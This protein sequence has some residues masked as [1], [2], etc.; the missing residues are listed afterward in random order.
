MTIFNRCVNDASR[1]TKRPMIHRPKGFENNAS[2][3]VFF[4]LFFSFHSNG[5]G[6][7][8]NQN[9]RRFVEFFPLKHISCDS[10]WC[11][12]T[13]HCTAKY[14]QSLVHWL[15]SSANYYDFHISKKSFQLQRPTER[16]KNPFSL[17]TAVLDNR[18]SFIILSPQAT[19]SF[20]SQMHILISIQKKKCCISSVFGH[21]AAYLW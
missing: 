20:K 18:D 5:N 16:M 6:F 8:L 19:H 21:I 12:S 15:T 14:I 13:Q 11:G 4:F 7:R 1:R 9:K 17:S 3:V 10:V 2:S